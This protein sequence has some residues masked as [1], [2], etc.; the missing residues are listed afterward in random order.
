MNFP[1]K[2]SLKKL[3]KQ[4]FKLYFSGALIYGLGILLFR[5]LPYY[6]KTLNPYTQTTLLLLYCS[7]LLITPIYYFVYSFFLNARSENAVNQSATTLSATTPSAANQQTINQPVEKQSAT[8]KPYLVLTGI[9]RAATSFKLEK[10]EKTAFL[11]MLVKLFFLPTMLNFCYENISFLIINLNMPFYPLIF[12]MLFTIDTLVFCFGYAFEFKFL[13][14]VVKSVE[15][16]L[17]GW[18][19]ALICYPPFN[20]W[21]GKYIPWGANDY[22]VFWNV[23][24]TIIIRIILILL[25]LIYVWATIALGTKSS[26]LTNRGIVRKF[27]YSMVRHPAYISKNL[28]WWLTLLPVINVP[29]AL[30]M[31]FWTVIYYFRALTE[32][33]HLKHDPEYIEYCQKVKYKFIPY[34]V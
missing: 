29:F 15:P 4:S 26:N 25:L 3:I 34:L 32:E 12:T 14:N 1:P 22:V 13:K 17:F 31:L 5:Y 16:T 6:K 10:E 9:K 27:P 23:K 24:I 20:Q 28:I 8:N 18:A 30:G 7:Y 2:E 33:R 11:F 19:V 21:V